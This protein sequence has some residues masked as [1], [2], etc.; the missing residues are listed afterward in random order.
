ME[1]TGPQAW[2][3]LGYVRGTAQVWVDGCDVGARLWHPFRFDLGTA[4]GPGRHRLRVRV[5]NT[6]GAHYEVGRPTSLVGKGQGAAGLYGPV[7]LQ[8]AA[9]A[10]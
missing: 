8:E 6:L 2:L 3:D 9:G 10:L 7:R 1:G 5:T 4:W